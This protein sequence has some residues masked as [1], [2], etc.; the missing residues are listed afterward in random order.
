MTHG[1]FPE[2]PLLFSPTLAA[3][4]GLEDAILVEVLRTFSVYCPVKALQH[5]H[6][7]H[8]SRLSLAAKVPFLSLDQVNQVLKRLFD[9]GLIVWDQSYTPTSDMMWLAINIDQTNTQI[10]PQPSAPS[11]PEQSFRQQ[12]YQQKQPPAQHTQA[13]VAMTHQWKPEQPTVQHLIQLGVAAHFIEQQ[14]NEF[15]LYWMERGEKQSAWGS[16]FIQHIQV[17]W[18]DAQNH[19]LVDQSKSMSSTWRP[20]EEAITILERN[21]IPDDFI[22]DCIPE[23][24]LYWKDRGDK[25]TTW[26]SKFIQHVK[27]QWAKMSSAMQSNEPRPMTQDW[28]PSADCYDIINLANI[29]TD[30]AKQCVQEFILYW[31]E[32]GEVYHAWNSKFIQ[33][34]KRKWA[35]QHAWQQGN[36]ERQQPANQ[37]NTSRSKNVYDRLNDTS[38]ASLDTAD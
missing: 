37:H 16:K 34:V 3:T 30:F 20:S 7:F 27:I 26:N 10:Q 32:T 9:K 29:N 13:K 25:L 15:V 35:K 21:D 6:W 4:I 1:L 18:R 33:Q 31:C 11:Q 24:V 19:K 22:K 2:T 12:L 8:I 14:L 38:W 36:D 5:R 28:Q 23:F 17:K